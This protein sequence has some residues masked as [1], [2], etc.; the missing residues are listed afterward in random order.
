MLFVAIDFLSQFWALDMPIHRVFQMY[1]Y[2]IPGALQQFV[3]VACLMASLLVL[4]AMSKQ[5]EVLALYSSGVSTLRLVSTFVALVATISTVA[6][7]ICDPVVPLLR[8][9]AS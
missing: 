9:G 7:L 3:P 2:M 8:N 4:S 6:F 5:N 1:G